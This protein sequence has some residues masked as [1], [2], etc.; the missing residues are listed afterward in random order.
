MGI[1]SNTASICQFQVVGDLPPGNIFD[2]I[3]EC[4]EK[5][6]F[7]GIENGAEELS[8]GWVRTDDYQS[9]DFAGLQ[10]FRRDHYA[11]FTLRRDQRRIPTPLLKA[12]QQIAEHEFLSANPGFYK[13][14][15]QKREDIRDAVRLSLLARALPS[16]AMYDVVWDT[17]NG[18]ITLA[19]LSQKIIDLFETEFK[20][21]FPGLRLLMIH[22]FA[23]AL[24]IS[25][26]DL[27]PE[28]EKANLASTESIL[29]L[30]RSNI[31]IG[32][33]FLLWLLHQTMTG[34]GEHSVCTSGIFGS[35][36]PFTAFMNDR[37]LLQA[38][39][40]SGTQRITVAGA[41][42]NFS[43]V[44]AALNLGK[45]ITEATIHFEKDEHSW[46]LTLKGELFHFGSFKCPPVQI[47]KDNTADKSAEMEAVFYERMHL[48]EC[49]TQLFDSLFS[50]FLRERLGSDWVVKTGE[51]KE[52]LETNG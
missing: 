41:Q 5:F 34:S 46:K 14:P 28:L 47:E 20:K 13:V 42:D 6:S 24:R 17:R 30:I 39:G 19:S 12:Y 38:S 22:P 36:E 11:S 51:I 44:L 32:Q 48:L 7:S 10:L 50:A 9:T 21:S 4:L 35:G 27:A 49:G 8:I 37:L 43:E 3:G 40:E 25:A 23:R 45:K 29:D 31:W 26:D 16:P 18:L 15:K 33:D 1:M 52:W 2:W